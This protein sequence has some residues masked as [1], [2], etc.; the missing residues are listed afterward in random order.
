[1][2]Y[3]E[4]LQTQKSLRRERPKTCSYCGH[5]VYHNAKRHG[6]QHPDK[7]FIELAPGQVPSQGFF[8]SYY[9]QG[10]V[11]MEFPGSD[12]DLGMDAIITLI[13]HCYKIPKRY[14]FLATAAVER[15]ERETYDQLR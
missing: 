4:T 2:H 5:V 9:D 3:A 12:M 6:L 13:K 1:M 8:K 10:T 14:W 11:I 15:Y 7:V